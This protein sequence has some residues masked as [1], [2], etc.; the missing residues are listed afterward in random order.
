MPKKYNRKRENMFSADNM[1][2]SEHYET[3]ELHN[4]KKSSVANYVNIASQKG[5]EKFTPRYT[6][7]EVLW[8]AM[9]ISLEKYLV[10]C[11]NIYHSLKPTSTRKLAYEYDKLSQFKIQAKHCRS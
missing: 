1:T 11:S 2:L 7:R 4:V 6:T 5:F 8:A 9:E 10:K 3:A